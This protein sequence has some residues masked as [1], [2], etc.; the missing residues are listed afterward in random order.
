MLEK[1]RPLLDQAFRNNSKRYAVINRDQRRNI[2]GF[3]HKIDPR[4]LRTIN[5]KTRL[6]NE[7]KMYSGDDRILEEDKRF[8][9]EIGRTKPPALIR[10]PHKG[11]LP[12]L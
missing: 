3:I 4:A 6:V 7:S 8:L 11:L 10:S 9:S 12:E 1:S 2:D 5:S